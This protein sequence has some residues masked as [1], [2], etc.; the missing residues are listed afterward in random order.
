MVTKY[1]MSKRLGNFVLPDNDEVFLGLDYAHAKEHSESVSSAIDEEV[2]SILDEAYSKTLDVLQE[3]RVLLDQ[4]A[5]VLME[6][7]K[8]EGREFEE[9][10]KAYA[11]NYVDA[12]GDSDDPFI[13]ELGDAAA[14]RAT[15]GSAVE[16]TAGFESES[17][18]ESIEPSADRSSAD[19]ENRP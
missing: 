5:A 9:I 18:P 11:A 15:D 13:N 4:L 1:G 2:K 7:E 8:I 14:P 12:P 6:K 17:E 3:N 16:K 19:P 10:Y